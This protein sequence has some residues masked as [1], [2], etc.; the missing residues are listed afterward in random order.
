MER[1]S[2]V[3]LCRRGHVV[4]MFPS[5]PQGAPKALQT[6]T[7]AGGRCDAAFEPQVEALAN[8]REFVL[9]LLSRSDCNTFCGDG[10][11]RL[12]RRVFERVSVALL[13]SYQL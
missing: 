12:K 4:T 3:L 13:V 8:I 9:K 1:V 7:L 10:K 2:A 11:I 6:I 5:T